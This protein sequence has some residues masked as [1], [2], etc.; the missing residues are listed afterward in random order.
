MNQTSPPFILQSSRSTSECLLPL[1]QGV[2]VNALTNQSKTTKIFLDDDWAI[3]NAAWRKMEE[4]VVLSKS[5]GMYDMRQWFEKYK[6]M[7]VNLIIK[8]YKT[9]GAY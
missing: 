2:S 3:L 7:S 9:E 4:F 5:Q 1:E 6:K 8:T